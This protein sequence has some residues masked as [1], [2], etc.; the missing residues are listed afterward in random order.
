MQQQKIL[1]I[2]GNYYP[3]PT[4]IGKY[5][6]EM[7]TWLTDNG[8]NCTVISTY[9]YYPS[10]RIQGLYSKKKGWYY[11]EKLTTLKGNEIKIYRCPHYVPLRPTGKTRMLLDFSFFVFAGLRL[12]SLTG[13]KFDYAISVTPP[14]SLG[15]LAALYK[16]VSQAK[17]LY[18]IQDLQIDAADSLNMIS[19]K[20]L[21]NILYRIEKYI[22][23]KADKISTISEGIAD[24]VKV[25]TDKPVYIVPNWVN[26]KKFYLLPDKAL[27]KKAYGF[28][29]DIPVILYSGSIGEKQG[30]E[31]MLSVAEIFI[32]ENLHTQFVISGSG[33]YKTTLEKIAGEK[34]LNNVA[35]LPLQPFEKLNAFLN[36]AD[37][38]LVIQKA[39]VADAVMP[40]KLTTILSVS[41]LAIVTANEGSG[42][43]NM[44]S[45]HNIGLLCKADSVKSLYE[46]IKKILINDYTS[47]CINAR[48]YAEEFLSVDRIMKHYKED[49]IGISD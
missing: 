13:K 21:L 3:E 1:L 39:D 9:P 14:L 42:L 6:G 32:K 29:P 31:V 5:N 15:F 23:K 45:K 49:V 37:A 17:F 20:K 33:P 11:K 8:F 34:R 48:N 44:V 40:S 18:H 24:K 27:S 41:G 7:M 4:G 25:K 47:I 43:Y 36:I 16:N 46:T 12:I 35:F 22:F 38:H 19:S 2:A 10:W 28:K 30:L 26:V